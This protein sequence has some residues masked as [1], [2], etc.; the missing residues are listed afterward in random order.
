MYA[1]SGD[2]RRGTTAGANIVGHDSAVEAIVAHYKYEK[3]KISGSE[4][5]DHT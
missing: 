2:S 3:H 4:D 5:R 1:R